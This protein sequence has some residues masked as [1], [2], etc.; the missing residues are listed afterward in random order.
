[1]AKADGATAPA[2]GGTWAPLAVPL[3]RRIWIG[4]LLSNLGIL[5]QTVGAAWAMTLMTPAADMVALVQT[6]LMLPVM[7]IAVPAGAVADMYDRRKVGIVALLLALS[8]AAIFTGLSFAGLMT[9]W[10]LLGYCFMVGTGWAMMSPALQSAV[11]E[12]VPPS[13]L[14]QAVALNSIAFN[15]ARSLGPA[16]GG[17]IVAAAGA[18][19]A[20]ALNALLYIPPIA[21]LIVWRRVQAPSRLPP[22]RLGWA[23]RSGVRYAFHTPAIRVILMRSVVTGL[24]GGSVASLMPL[25]ARDLI[26]GGAQVYGILL[27][28]FGVGAVLGGLLVGPITRRFPGERAV[29][30]S[31]ILLGVA[32][33]IIAASSSLPI[34]ALALIAAGMMWIVPI[35]V[36]NIGAQMSA[37]RWVS[38]RTLATFQASVAGGTAIGSWLWGHVA[39][40]GGVR[41]ALFCSAALLGVTALIGRLLPMPHVQQGDKETVQYDDPE[42]ALAI[43]GRSGPILVEIDYRVPAH[44]ARVF[45][46]AMQALRHIR[47]RNGVVEWQIARDL[48]DE[49]LWIERYSCPTWHDY[50]RQRSRMTPADV[51]V[52]DLAASFHIGDRQGRVRRLLERPFGSVRWRDDTPDPGSAGLAPLPG[53]IGAA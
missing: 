40:D 45:Y 43:T 13:A 29:R 41:L 11:S 21:V 26:G 6:A 12:Q 38:G 10:L 36:F 44:Q 17:M 42:I 30:G 53:E 14:P 39:D 28:S 25:V 24:A 1:M 37:P 19:A 46:D 35:T 23:I 16:I 2:A 52:S 5:I 32:V 33:A 47:Q 22:E 4:T 9:P 31:T 18:M 34:S 7:L 3:F 15:M 51:A 49:E 50:L 8:S 48:S 20:F 27:G